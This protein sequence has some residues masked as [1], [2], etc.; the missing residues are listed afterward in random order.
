VIPSPAEDTL[1]VADQTQIFVVAPDGRVLATLGRA[2]RGPGEFTRIDGISPLHGDS[3][4]VW[5]GGIWRLTW[6]RLDGEVIRTK[7]LVPPGMHQ[8]PRPTLL[9]P[10]PRGLA[11]ASAFGI[12]RTDGVPDTVVIGLVIDDADSVRRVAATPDLTWGNV[13]GVVGPRYP[14]GPRALYAVSASGLLALSDGVE[15]CIVIVAPG[16]AEAPLRICRTWRREPVGAAGRPPP[17]D[18]T[19]LGR[20]GPMLRRVVEA[21]EPGPRK[22]SIDRMVFDVVDRLWVRVVDSTHR[23]HPAYMARVPTLRPGTFTWEVFGRD[24]RL[25]HRVR[26]PSR[27]SPTWITET[28]AF[29]LMDEDDG[30]T[31]IARVSLPPA[32]SVRAGSQ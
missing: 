30:T 23:H 15:Y 21:Q 5:D 10:L 12:I 14:F 2:G 19:V 25:A 13:G 20:V 4:V 32:L 8:A 27:F 28:A 17:V 11:V 18:D 31:T 7:R 29:G 9:H 24:G 16:T 22:N 6:M 1:L 26:L 3:L